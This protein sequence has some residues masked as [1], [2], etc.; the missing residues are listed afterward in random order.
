[1]VPKLNRN[2]VGNSIDGKKICHRVAVASLLLKIAR[3]RNV[4]LTV[5]EWPGG[6][7]SN[8]SFRITESEAKKI[9]DAKSPTQLKLGSRRPRLDVLKLPWGSTGTFASKSH[10][11][12][13]VI[14]PPIFRAG[15]WKLPLP[16]GV[17]RLGKR[18]KA[19]KIEASRENRLSGLEARRSLR[20]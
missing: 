4:D 8:K 2:G 7:P 5:A 9:Y 17:V 1:M 15:Q 13:A 16:L 19:L 20:T 14:D 10:A 11:F 3:R 6:S 18:K 12:Q